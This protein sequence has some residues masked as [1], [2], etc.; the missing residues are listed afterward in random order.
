M[1]R[2]VRVVADKPDG[3]RQTG[4][5]MG[6]SRLSVYGG[7]D[8]AFGATASAQ[9]LDGTPATMHP[10]GA[11][12]NAVDRNTVTWAQATNQFLW[13]LILDLGASQDVG[14]V[15]VL[16]PAAAFASEFHLDTSVDGVT[17]AALPHVTNVGV[18]GL[19]QTV[20]GQVQ[21]I[22]YVRIVAD[23]PNGP[24]QRG[25]QMGIAEVIVAR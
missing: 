21:A 22:R 23:L 16:M 3:P 24:G 7:P 18:G 20:L 4:G 14:E 15:D 10:F 12:S 13:R 19:V 11:A 2:Y 17:W 8:L 25:G 9:Y 1:A 5:Q 6:I